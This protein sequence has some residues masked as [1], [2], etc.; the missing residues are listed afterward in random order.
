[1]TTHALTPSTLGQMTLMALRY[2]NGRRLRTVL[3]TLSIVFGVALIFAINLTL[4]PLSAAFNSTLSAY[5]AADI[6]ISGAAA[7]AFSPDAVAQA[8][9][10]PGV[11]A[12]AGLLRRQFSL[13]AALGAN[14]ALGSANT[15]ELIGIDPVA[16]LDV[17]QM[18]MAEGRFLQA[19]DSGA[20]LLPAG[21]AELAPQ[22][23]VGT[24]FP[25]IT[26]AGLRVYTVVGLSAEQGNF[27][28]PPL[29][30][31]LPD[32]QAAFGQPGL[33]NTIEIAVE[34]GADRAAVTEAVLAALGPAFISGEATTGADTIA[35]TVSVGLLIMNLFG[36]LALFLG[37]FLIF[38]TFRTIVVERRRDL[39]MLRALG[40]TR[41]QVTTMIVIESLIQ[42]V[43]GSVIGLGLGTLLALGLTAMFRSVYTTYF[44]ALSF[45]LAFNLGA[46]VQ[47]VGMGIAA[48]VLAGYWPARAAGRTS[49]LDALRPQTAAAANRATRSSVIIGLGL[50]GLAIVMLF[51][52]P[53]AAVGGALVF[54]TGLIVAAPA[55][56]LPVA[57]LFSPILALWF[58]RE[59]DLARGN[60]LRQPGR[61]A[62]TATTL[63]IGLAVLIVMTAT[64]SAFGS[65]LDRLAAVNFSSDIIITPPSIG[66]YNNVLGA[67]STLIDGLRALPQTETAASLRYATSSV[68]GASETG[69]ELLGIDPAA[70]PE[71]ASLSFSQGTAEDA[72]AGLVQP[73]TAILSSL[74]ASTL[75]LNLGD[76]FTLQTANG[77]QTYSVVGVGD[78]LFTFKLAALFVSQETLAADFNITED[79]LLML[80]FTPGADE[81][82]GLAAVEGVLAEY[83]QFTANLTGQ[84]RDDLI[85]T[86]SATF[87][88][89]YVLAALIIIPAAL[90]LLNT[91]TINIMERTREIGIVRAV[92]G[93][94]TQVRRIVTAE[95]LLLGLFASAL[96]VLAGVAMSYGF[97]GAFS[98]LGWDMPVI[99]PVA[100]IIASVVL[101]VLVALF[102]SVLPARNAAKLDIIRALQY[103]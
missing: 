8:A 2:L 30:L 36:V 53:E 89:F 45:D 59:G 34:P 90:G 49:P 74:G 95:A 102:A 76:T 75:S 56:I 77:P 92:G 13:P 41:R 67:D 87:G 101:G 54:L 64:V 10:V 28:T 18:P 39:G 14:N 47:A 57:N 15:V 19:D 103:Q 60:L 99:F 72:F 79:V 48:S 50:I 44:S 96:G 86:T 42:G 62:I 51:A 58:A 7:S 93:S 82:A 9:Q 61:A 88:I 29:Y 38:N 80:T 71:V 91:L 97:V 22:L 1:M 52:G 46:L 98:T 25:L 84:Y 70:Y 3:T 31:N 65:L 40:A 21:L 68:S 63:M 33:I 17:R 23:G 16:G 12:A 81:Q 73:R 6:T 43:I 26:A 78:D 5:G 11:R 94:R 4:P 24:T 83:P 37:A 100:G 32:V 20:V 85:E 69:V 27:A 55:L 35:S 66:L